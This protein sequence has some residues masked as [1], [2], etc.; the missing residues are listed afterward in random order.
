MDRTTKTFYYIRKETDLSVT[1]IWSPYSFY[2]PLILLSL[3]CLSALLYIPFLAI[4]FLVLIFSNTL[5]Y[6]LECKQANAEIKSALKFSQV[7]VT[8]NKYSFSSPLTVTILKET[9]QN[10]STIHCYRDSFE[11]PRRGS[12]L[13]KAILIILT[14]ILGMISI[15]MFSSMML[16]LRQAANIGSIAILLSLSIIF[17]LLA[18]L[19]FK[20]AKK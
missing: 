4:I 17:F 15:L 19:C 2:L 5:F 12:T 13:K 18:Y 20:Q 6:L 8:G 1:I 11:A 7:N 3:F 10:S 16:G 14:T 9:S